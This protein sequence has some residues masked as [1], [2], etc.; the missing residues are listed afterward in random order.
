[1]NIVLQV[2]HQSE[3]A[4]ML[5]KASTLSKDAKGVEGNGADEGRGRWQYG[6]RVDIGC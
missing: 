4:V 6:W 1:M 2:T 5:Q 3:K